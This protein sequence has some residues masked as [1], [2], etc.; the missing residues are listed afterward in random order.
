MTISYWLDAGH[1][2]STISLFNF[3]NKHLSVIFMLPC[4]GAIS[5]LFLLYQ[6]VFVNSEDL[7]FGPDSSSSLS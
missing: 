4:V 3:F 6:I 5:T 2:W 1:G 7:S